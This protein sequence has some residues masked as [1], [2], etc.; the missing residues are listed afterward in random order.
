VRNS[1]ARRVWSVAQTNLNVKVK[2][3][4]S[5][6][7][8]TRV[9]KCPVHSHH[10]RQ[11]RNGLVCCTQRIT[12]HCQRGR[13]ACGLCLVK[14]ICCSFSYYFYYNIVILWRMKLIELVPNM[15][16][17]GEL[18]VS[19]VQFYCGDVNS[20]LLCVNCHLPLRDVSRSRSLSRQSACFFFDPNFSLTI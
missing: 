12:M 2:G 5:N 19:S 20:A 10:P 17:N 11:R 18:A 7:K 3:Q 4:R 8:V 1:Q 13:P 6:V 15:F 16:Q 9:K 14:R